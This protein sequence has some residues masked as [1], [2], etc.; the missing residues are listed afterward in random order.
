ME[1]LFTTSRRTRFP[2]SLGTEACSASIASLIR[3]YTCRPSLSPRASMKSASSGAS[4]SASVR[5]GIACT[6]QEKSVGLSARREVP[7]LVFKG[8]KDQ[9]LPHSYGLAGGG[10][11]AVARA[12]SLCYQR[13]GSWPGS[14]RRRP[15]ILPLFKPARTLIPCPSRPT[16]PLV[17]CTLS[18]ASPVT[19]R[20]YRVSTGF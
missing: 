8:G 16:E 18:C 19:G 12:Q 17:D 7:G 20:R 6:F 2:S 5:F 11:P 4:I 10:I 14:V 15:S 9:T 13:G 3:S 1:R